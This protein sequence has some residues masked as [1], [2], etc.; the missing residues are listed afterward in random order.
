MS[1]LHDEVVV[2]V[3]VG[4]VAWYVLIAVWIRLAAGVKLRCREY[5]RKAVQY[6]LLSPLIVPLHV[7]LLIGWVV[8]SLI[9]CG[10]LPF[11]WSDFYE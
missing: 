3:A 10:L 2:A 7:V 9:S 4:V 5:R 6:W 8:V 1:A 11:P